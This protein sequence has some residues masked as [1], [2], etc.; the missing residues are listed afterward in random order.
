VK[1]KNKS[2]VI[3]NWGKYV[4]PVSWRFDGNVEASKI[5]RGFAMKLIGNFR[6]RMALFGQKNARGHWIGSNVQIYWNVI[7]DIVQCHIETPVIISEG[8]EIYPILYGFAA[9]L[10]NGF[11]YTIPFNEG[12]AA[13]V[14]PTEEYFVPYFLNDELDPN[15]G[16]IVE[17]PPRYNYM[18][19][20]VNISTVSRIEEVEDINEC[21]DPETDEIAIQE[22]RIDV[23]YQ[24]CDEDMALV[25]PMH[26]LGASGPGIPGENPTIKDMCTGFRHVE[27]FIDSEH[28]LFIGSHEIPG[29]F[30]LNEDGNLAFY[31]VNVSEGVLIVTLEVYDLIT[32][33]VLSSVTKH[34]TDSDIVGFD[35]DTVAGLVEYISF[36][37]LV[38]GKEHLSVN[39]AGNQVVFCWTSDADI[40]KT[41]FAWLFLFNENGNDFSINVSK[42][43][44][45]D[46]QQ[47]QVTTRTDTYTGSGSLNSSTVKH[48]D[49]ASGRIFCD[50]HTSSSEEI[51][52]F[53]STGTLDIY[54]DYGESI[55]S[56]AFD[57]DSDVLIKKTIKY[58]GYTKETY[59]VTQ[60]V[61][62]NNTASDCTLRT[63]TDSENNETK[64]FDHIEYK[65]SS[66]NIDDNPIGYH[67][68]LT[69]DSTFKNVTHIDINPSSN[70]SVSEFGEVEVFH[71]EHDNAGLDI[72]DLSNRV[73]KTEGWVTDYTDTTPYG[74]VLGAVYNRVG[75][76]K[77]T[78]K[79][80][81][82]TNEIFTEER[83][84][85]SRN[86]TN[87]SAYVLIV[88]TYTFP[89]GWDC[90]TD[91][92][93]DAGEEP[94]VPWTETVA[95]TGSY[96]HSYNY[97]D[98]IEQ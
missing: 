57:A 21:I 49:T 44:G 36:R 32:K 3:T 37:Y 5:Q 38:G 91:I 1:G 93:D 69:K 74:P 89:I 18:R 10:S 2:P 76:Y 6:Q 26:L 58:G 53:T 4:Y 40:G 79:I 96:S 78:Y 8:C 33:E 62:I 48:R 23:L 60:T 95:C 12:E 64:V 55:L 72:A 19:W 86:T 63:T 35:S 84:A 88:P 39:K 83:N 24:V 66:I 30:H 90:V 77:E 14:P 92:P 11:I 20:G 27:V 87:N 9:Q 42:V 65:S 7:G 16:A 51:H 52:V 41:E 15:Y 82:R 22:I 43:G 50:S 70:T 71:Q 17:Y 98:G 25:L 97:I 54:Y 81:A 68:T 13:P 67:D 73:Y 56:A 75:N 46:L 94:E 34:Y 80:H 45:E 29:G 61:T 28:F 59:S 31:T 47:G 85:E